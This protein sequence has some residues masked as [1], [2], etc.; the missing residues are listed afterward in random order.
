[1]QWIKTKP[2]RTSEPVSLRVDRYDVIE[3]RDSAPSGPC[4][5]DLSIAVRKRE[6][7]NGGRMEMILRD[8][9]EY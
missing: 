7:E 9:T 5:L 1:M 2:H 6:W 3:G 4:A 8:D